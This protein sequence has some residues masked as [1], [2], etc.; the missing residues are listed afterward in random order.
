MLQSYKNIHAVAYVLYIFVQCEIIHDG[1][2]LTTQCIY[3]V[4][5]YPCGIQPCSSSNQFFFIHNIMHCTITPNLKAT[6]T[7]IQELKK[8]KTKSKFTHLS[9]E[10]LCSVLSLTA[11]QRKQTS[12]RRSTYPRVFI[13]PV[14][15]THHE[16][17][18]SKIITN[19]WLCYRCNLRYRIH[20]SKQCQ[21]FLF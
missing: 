12:S 16:L 14:S 7:F 5:H 18:Y 8:K 13:H 3:C 20:V 11:M 19:Q 1:A 6:E 4:T 21:L 10:I 2:F 15:V 9:T 17:I